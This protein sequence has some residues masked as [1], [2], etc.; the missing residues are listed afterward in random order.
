MPGRKVLA[1]LTM[2]L[3]CRF[4]VQAIDHPG[5]SVLAVLRTAARLGARPSPGHRGPDPGGQASR[6]PH[7]TGSCREGGHGIRPS[8]CGSSGGIRRADRHPDPH[9]RRGRRTARRPRTAIEVAPAVR[10]TRADGRGWSRCFLRGG[11]AGVGAG[12]RAC[13]A[14]LVRRGGSAG[15][16]ADACVAPAPQGRGAAGPVRGAQQVPQA[17]PDLCR[18]RLRTHEVLEDPASRLLP[19]GEAVHH[20]MRG[21]AR[22]H[23]LNLGG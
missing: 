3:E 14:M 12:L 15:R 10:S 22:V 6:Q 8:T 9:R 1:T 7:A 13:A 11:P 17:G 20:A 2:V 19:Q 21:I 16:R 5:C 23:D 4:P 18:A